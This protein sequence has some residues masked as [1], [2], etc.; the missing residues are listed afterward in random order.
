MLCFTTLWLWELPS[1]EIWCSEF[2]VTLGQKRTSKDVNNFFWSNLDGSFLEDNAEYCIRVG[3]PGRKDCF[4]DG[5]QSGLWD[6][7]FPWRLSNSRMGSVDL[8]AA[9]K[10]FSPL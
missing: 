2:A 8:S 10:S 9:E 1:E 5:I 7:R 4:V 6:L 3:Q